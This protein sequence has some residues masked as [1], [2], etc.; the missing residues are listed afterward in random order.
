MQA[1]L[2]SDWR[3]MYHGRGGGVSPRVVRTRA[4]A[5]SSVDYERIDAMSR[6]WALGGVGRNE[7]VETSESDVGL[8]AAAHAHRAVMSPIVATAMIGFP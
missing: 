5:Q 7:V 2:G 1:L 4:K 3:Q 6:E 8:D